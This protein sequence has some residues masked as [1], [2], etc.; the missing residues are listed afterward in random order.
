MKSIF[1]KHIFTIPSKHAI[2]IFTREGNTIMIYLVA[3]GG[4]MTVLLFVQVFFPKF[5]NILYTAFNFYRELK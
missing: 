5:A 1:Q 3:R 4:E 2:C